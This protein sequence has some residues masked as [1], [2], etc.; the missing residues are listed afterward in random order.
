MSKLKQEKDA[1]IDTQ[2]QKI[3]RLEREN[4]RL[5]RALIDGERCHELAKTQLDTQIKELEAEKRRL[6]VKLDELDALVKKER[7]DCRAEKD[8]LKGDVA[9]LKEQL[10]RATSE[11]QTEAANLKRRLEEL[12]R[13][14]QE[15]RR[16]NE[17]AEEKAAQLQLALDRVNA[18][19]DAL[20][21]IPGIEVEILSKQLK[22]KSDALNRLLTAMNSPL[23]YQKLLQ[24]K[25]RAAREYDTAIL[26]KSN[27][28]AGLENTVRE[29]AVEIG[30]L[31]SKLAS[32]EGELE[33][34]KARYGS[35]KNTLD[36]IMK[37]RTLDA[38]ERQKII[39]EQTA[40]INELKRELDE[41]RART[42]ELLRTRD[43]LVEKLSTLSSER[44]RLSVA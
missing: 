38:S 12:E 7:V 21:S 23:A 39:D 22:E 34:Y 31:K 19:H 18:D 5:N 44:D 32:K 14:N 10:A 29:Q 36:N 26:I 43:D 37:L 27:E 15:L 42:N 24:E 9:E 28:I 4:G 16:A 13:S 20:K 17:Q 35:T 41:S 25:E 11:H 2:R 30:E 8:K 33:D 6:Q 3:D 40:S 1:V